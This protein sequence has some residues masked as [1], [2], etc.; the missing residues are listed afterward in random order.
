MARRNTDDELLMED[1]LS[2]AFLGDDLAVEGMEQTEEISNAQSNEW[3]EEENMVPGQLAL[4]VYETKEK[5]IVKARTAGVNKNDLDVR[6]LLFEQPHHLAGLRDVP[7]VH[8]KTDDLHIFHLKQFGDHVLCVARNRE[9]AQRRLRAQ[10]THVRQQVA[11]AQRRV[12]VFRVQGA[13]DDGGHPG[14]IEA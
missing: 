8:T 4:D 12:D 13:Q 10:V 1:E 9:L 14:I 3:D 7:D 5:L 6:P 2:A 11:Q